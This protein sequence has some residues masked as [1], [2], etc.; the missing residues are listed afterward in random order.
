[1]T[2]K[3]KNSAH[4]EGSFTGACSQV[5][6]TPISNSETELCLQS[7]EQNTVLRFQAKRENFR[8]LIYKHKCPKCP[9]VQTLIKQAFMSLYFGHLPIKPLIQVSASVHKKRVKTLKKPNTRKPYV[10][11]VYR[12][13]FWTRGHLGHL[14]LYRR[15]F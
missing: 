14:V 10:S 6:L 9:S 12:V 3:M 5:K 8:K 7:E 2:V 11:N 1:M 13:S 4:N 15:Q